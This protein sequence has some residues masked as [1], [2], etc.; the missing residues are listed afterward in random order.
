[1]IRTHR[2]EERG[3]SPQ[4]W[5]SPKFS[6]SFARYYNPERMGFGALRVL[7]NDTI[8]PGTGFPTHP[9]DNMEIITIPLK[10]A[11]AHKDSTGKEEVLHP[12]DVQVMSAG[13]GVLHSEYN[14]SDTEELELFQ[15]WIE[16]HTL[17]VNP[18]HDERSFVAKENEL[19]LLVSGNKDDDALFIHQDAKIL[20]GKF[21][22]DKSFNYHLP[23]GQGLFIMPIYGE[24][25]SMGEH[26]RQRD[27]LEV[28]DKK[29]I[30]IT[31][32]TELDILL[33]EVPF[34]AF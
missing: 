5:L 29:E 19:Q 9:H 26:L 13:A 7:N 21:N 25:S 28:T 20:R 24:A 31:A 27:S 18:Q 14:A 4:G 3:G 8:Q 1:M 11:L 17:G 23:Q 22:K 2:S 12:G 30:T 16:P 34:D 10:G 6:F 33:I 15:L 32:T